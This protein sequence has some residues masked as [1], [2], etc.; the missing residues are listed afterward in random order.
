MSY[1]RATHNKKRRP[2]VL[3]QGPP[4]GASTRSHTPMGCMICRTH[5]SSHL[6]RQSPAAGPSGVADP[7]V[8]C[9]QPCLMPPNTDD[10]RTQKPGTLDRAMYCR[11]ESACLCCKWLH[12]A[13]GKGNHLYRRHRYG[14]VGRL[15]QVL[16]HR[17]CRL[18]DAVGTNVSEGPDFSADHY[19][20]R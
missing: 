9:T 11:P 20:M 19:G 16:P 8:G 13:A 6:R 10:T 4:G 15:K 3:A 2:S 1:R 12:I 7:W 14:R 18:T 5:P 17:S